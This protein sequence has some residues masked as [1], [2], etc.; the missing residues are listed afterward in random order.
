MIKLCTIPKKPGIYQ[1]LDKNKDILYIGKAKNLSNRVKSYFSRSA[2]LSP[3]KRTMVNNIKHIK[4]TIVDN[5]TEALLLERTLIRKHQPPFNI[6]LKDDKYFLYIKIDFNEDYP[7]I[8]TTR[9]FQLNN[10]VK[11]FGPYTSGTAVHR[12]VKLIKKIIAGEIGWDKYWQ[13]QKNIS[14]SKISKTKYNNIIKQVIQL[15][16][17]H[18]ADIIK[19]LTEKMEIASNEKNYELAA[20]YRDYILAIKSLQTKQRVVSNNKNN[21]DYLTIYLKDKTSVIN[22]F[23]VRSGKLIEQRNFTINHKEELKEVDVLNEFCLQYY[24]QT[25]DIP[26]SVISNYKLNTEIKNII[27]KKGD[28]LKLLK[29]GLVNAKDYASKQLHSWE[30]DDSKISKALNQLQ[31]GLNLKHKLKRIE[32]Y[33]ISNIQGVYAVGS[34]VVFTDGKPNKSQYRKFKIKSITGPDDHH[35]MQEVVKRRLA[36]KDWPNPDL[37]ILD[38]GKPQLSTVLKIKEV[39][40]DRIVA[41]AK[42]EELIHTP[43]QE[44][45]RFKPGSEGYFLLQRMRDEAHRF[46]ISFYRKTHQNISTS[47]QLD[48]LTGIGPKTKKILKDKYGS[49]HKIQTANE[50][51]LIKLIGKHKTDIIKKA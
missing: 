14:K 34:M 31:K 30:K 13:H 8:Q 49:W 1:F 27:P 32:T 10:K 7:N 42:K 19:S 20:T 5:E 46:A 16:S 43:E 38:G 51:E 21:E 2:D 39:P 50:K 35:M 26:K 40:R 48:N 6:D 37:I 44:V 36:H 4:Y 11:Y 15:L 17:G 22:L 28:K 9:N 45:I 25:T 41:L 33:D 47:S 23:K 12:T 3:A 18:N 29:L 24:S